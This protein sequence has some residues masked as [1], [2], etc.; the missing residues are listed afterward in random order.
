MPLTETFKALNAEQLL[1]VT[2]TE[3]Y[4]RVMAGAGTGK[5]KA[6]T[7]RYAYLVSELGISPSNI[8]TVT[9]TNRA[10]NEM[11]SRIRTML[12]D[13]DLGQISTI[14]AFCARFLKDEI[15]RLGYPKSF[16]VID[17]DDEKE[18]LQRIFADMKISLRETT[19]QRT[20]D[21][22]LEAGKMTDAYIDEFLR[23]SAEELL[24][25][26]ADDYYINS[27]YLGKIFT[28]KRKSLD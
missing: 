15:N 2:T 10:A 23:I 21:E 16:I 28:R 7:A 12:G 13:L 24:Q 3:G 6:L 11:K 4:V 26:I 14:H 20:I 1:A 18:M 19:M 25:K 8:L 22:V 9:F 5:T 27:A 17:T